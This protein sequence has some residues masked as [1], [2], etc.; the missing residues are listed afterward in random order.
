[1][2]YK[3]PRT[4]TILSVLM[5]PKIVIIKTLIMINDTN[6]NVTEIENTFMT[7]REK[8]LYSYIHDR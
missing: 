2:W 3:W 5:S 4:S 6:N 1:M 7:F 8:D